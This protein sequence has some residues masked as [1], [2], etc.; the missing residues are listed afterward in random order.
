MDRYLFKKT[1]KTK[2]MGYYTQF[3]LKIKDKPHEPAEFHKK[4]ISKMV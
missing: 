1:F 2:T 3:D 4:E